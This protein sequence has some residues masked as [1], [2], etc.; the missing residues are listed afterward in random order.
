MGV[1]SARFS[2]LVPTLPEAYA[3][4]SSLSCG[5]PKGGYIELVSRF[6]LRLAET[7]AWCATRDWANTPTGELRT[8]NLRPDHRDGLRTVEL[9]PDHREGTDMILDWKASNQQRAEVVEQLAI[10][11]A[12][13]LHEH[14]I[15]VPK[16]V[17]PLTRGR[18]LAFNL[19]QTLSD[20]AANIASHGFL[21][22]DNI[23][24]WDT[25]IMYVT[26][27]PVVT[28]S[29]W[30]WG[31]ADSYLLSWIPEVFVD[32]VSDGIDVNPEACILWATDLT[33]PFLEH[34]C[35]LGLVR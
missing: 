22:C 13:L 9:R 25:W 27:D 35:Q 17:S 4:S 20:G 2:S 16:I 3:E 5:E 21:D 28:P 10:Q 30:T 18:L 29:A 24:A 7:M 33:S 6:H 11:R 15:L 8:A 14:N 1:A 12:Q 19:D 32:L 23:P 31:P 26:G 34:L